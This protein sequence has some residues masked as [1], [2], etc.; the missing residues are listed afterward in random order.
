MVCFYRGGFCFVC[1]YHQII[2]ITAF[3][4]R[5]VLCDGGCE[6][7]TFRSSSQ[8]DRRMDSR[9]IHSLSTGCTI[10]SYCMQSMDKKSTKMPGTEP[11]RSSL[12]GCNSPEQRWQ[13][14]R[15]RTGGA[16]IN[17]KHAIIIF[18]I[19]S[20]PLYAWQFQRN[21]A[22]VIILFWRYTYKYNFDKTHQ[23]EHD[24]SVCCFAHWYSDQ[25]ISNE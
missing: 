10:R 20:S 24:W 8:I 6:S 25:W 13:R 2:L 19:C 14:P 12:V 15:R 1:A 18:V 23:L 11:S 17:Y 7:V 5:G 9:R 22:Q 16:G 21:T 3:V 4:R